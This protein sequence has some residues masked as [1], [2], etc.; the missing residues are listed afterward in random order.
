MMIRE[1]GN[2][3]KMPA[4]SFRRKRVARKSGFAEYAKA[5]LVFI[6]TGG[7]LLRRQ[8]INR[9]KWREPYEGNATRGSLQVLLQHRM[10]IFSLPRNR[11]S[12]KFQ[13]SVLI[14]SAVRAWEK[15]RRKF[16][17][18]REGLQGLLLLHDSAQKREVRVY[19]FALQRNRGACSRE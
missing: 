2:L 17:I 11:R 4:H 10:R 19:S 8:K 14:L 7:C 18:Y 1:S 5:L 13:L 3:L 6:K 9:V 12:G 15:V 16:P